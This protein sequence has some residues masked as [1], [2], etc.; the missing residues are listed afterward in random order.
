MARLFPR[1][2]REVVE[3]AARPIM[4]KRGFVESSILLDWPHIVG[5]TLACQTQPLKLQFPRHSSTD[6]VLTVACTPAFAPELLQLSPIV[7]D[8]LATHLGYRAIARIAIEQHHTLAPRP[9][10]PQAK[11]QPV[12]EEIFSEDPV[13]NAL[14]RFEKIR[15]QEGDIPT[16]RK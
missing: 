14:R 8:K 1:P 10:P 16:K 11:P 6:A 15:N 5:T 4:R 3:K 13:V 9:T 12:T 7:L 2:L